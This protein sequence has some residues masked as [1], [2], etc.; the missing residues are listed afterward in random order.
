M[1]RIA[2]NGVSLHYEE[3]GGGQDTAPET[4]VFA[5]GLLCAG[6]L[7]RRQLAA[8]GARYRCLAFDFRGHGASDAAPGGYDMASLCDEMAAFV[9]AAGGGP[10]HVLG[11]SMG[12]FVAQ[13]LALRHP[14]FVRSLVLINTTA[15]AETTVNALRY[16]ALAAAARC[17]GF[18]WLAGPMAAGMLGRAYR[19][20]PARVEDR[21]EL[22][23]TLAANRGPAALAAIAGVAGR[24]SIHDRLDRIGVP[25]LVIGGAEDTV[26]RPVHSLRMAERIAGAELHVL[27]GVGHCATLEAPDQFNA[28]VGRFLAAQ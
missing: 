6:T 2:V 10:C 18:G 17:V 19:R 27:P 11:H 8:L 21:A 7:F 14:A 9:A 3:S 15:D 25:T 13:L 22:R 23:R 12:G 24:T 16:R 4:L 5:H 28:L 26:T 20:D 1:P